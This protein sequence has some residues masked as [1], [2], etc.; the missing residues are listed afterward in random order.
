MKKLT[1]Q[2]KKYLANIG[3]PT[4]DFEQIEIALKFLRLENNK[5]E[6]LTIN[7]AIDKIGIQDFLSGLA[8]AAFHWTSFRNG[9][10]FNCSKMFK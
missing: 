6:A 8:R 10:Y 2:N 4:A 1:T 3:Y 5:D 9:V 7:E